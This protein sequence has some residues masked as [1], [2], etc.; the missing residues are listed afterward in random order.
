MAA[1]LQGGRQRQYHVVGLNSPFNTVNDPVLHKLP[2]I[3]VLF[4]I[5]QLLELPCMID[6]PQYH[7]K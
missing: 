5:E 6:N 1:S 7:S 3:H 2:E 4:V